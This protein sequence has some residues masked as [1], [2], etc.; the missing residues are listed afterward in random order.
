[1]VYDLRRSGFGFIK[2][3]FTSSQGKTDL[4]FHARECHQGSRFDN[5]RVGDEVSYRLDKDDRRGK[6]MAVEVRVV[7]RAQKGRA[8]AEGPPPKKRR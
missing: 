4:Y 3:D 5:M 8:P 1:M 2:P 7:K 6:P